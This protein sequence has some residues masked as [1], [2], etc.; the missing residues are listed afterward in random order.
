[1]TNCPNCQAARETDNQSRQYN[2]PQ[3]E[4]CTARL[5]KTIRGLAVARSMAA[6]RMS[7]VL[8]DAIGYGHNEL[9][10]RSMVKAGPYL[11]PVSIKKKE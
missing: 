11:A 6:A 3:C 9:Q 7:A 5:I 2:S 4:Y 10:V 8:A 1:M